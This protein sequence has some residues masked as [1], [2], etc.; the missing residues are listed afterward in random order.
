MT[1]IVDSISKAYGSELDAECRTKISRYLQTLNST[2]TRDNQ[3]LLTY[4][5]AYLAQLRNPDPRYTGC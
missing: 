5:L 3:Q 2:G 1:D 4:G